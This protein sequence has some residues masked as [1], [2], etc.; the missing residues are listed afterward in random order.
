MM[1]HFSLVGVASW[2]LCKN[3]KRVVKLEIQARD[4]LLKK[5]GMLVESCELDTS[6]FNDYE[7]AFALPLS[8]TKWETLQELFPRHGRRCQRE[9]RSLMG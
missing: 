3:K 4:V 6:A 1:H 5:W 7:Q 2:W 9:V 8:L